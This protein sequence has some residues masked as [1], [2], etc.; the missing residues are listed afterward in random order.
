VKYLIEDG[1][2]IDEGID[3]VI[4]GNI[5]NGAGLS[6]SAS[7]EL[8]AGIVF[9]RLAGLKVDRLDLVKL[10]KKVENQFFGL[11]SGIMD[12]FAIGMGEKDKALLLDT[13]TLKYEK[14]PVELANHVIVIMN[15]KKR[16]EL[17]DSKYNERL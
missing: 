10:G 13:N 15:T 2:R 4:E 5:P 8:L 9:E 3:L 17:V 16:R 11:N 6:S 1:H 14:I 12:Q 7:L